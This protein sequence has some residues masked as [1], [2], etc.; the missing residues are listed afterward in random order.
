[1]RRRPGKQSLAKQGQYEM[2]SMKPA[3]LHVD[4][5]QQV[6]QSYAEMC[7]R[8]ALTLTRNPKDAYTLT[9]DVL[10]WAMQLGDAPDAT[11]DIK[12]LLLIELRKRFLQDYRPH[13]PRIRGGKVV[14]MVSDTDFHVQG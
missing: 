9:R 11:K 2:N 10:I 12:S 13:T 4:V 14:A 8:V 7:Y 5:L 3:M 1:M 6:L